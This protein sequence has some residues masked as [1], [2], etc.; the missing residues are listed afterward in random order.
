MSWRPRLNGRS[1]PLYRQIVDALREDVKT[2][3]VAQ[4]TRLPPQRD[5]AKSLG[6]T[7]GTVARAYKQAQAEGLI[8]SGVGSG[9][10]VQAAARNIDD[11]G[12]GKSGLAR[13]SVV[14]LAQNSI[15]RLQHRADISALLTTLTAD[16]DFIAKI[17]YAPHAGHAEHRAAA[18][19]WLADDAEFAP[20]PDSIVICNGG[21]HALDIA[22]RTL[23]RPDDIILVEDLTYPGLRAA[24]A[25]FGLKLHPVGMDNEGL[26]P[27]HL[28][29]AAKK[30]GA[31]VLF[32]V[33]TM[34]TATAA[35]Q[36]DSRRRELAQIIEKHD[37]HVIE[38]G[39]FD[40]LLPQRQAPIASLIPQRCL[41][42]SSIGKV[43]SSALHCGTLV[44]PPRLEPRA[45]DAMRASCWSASPLAVAMAIEALLDG[46]A[47][48]L[49]ARN[50]AEAAH[51]QAI[52]RSIL[53]GLC[54]I[55]GSPHAYHIWITLETARAAAE[56]RN[57]LRAAN[58]AVAPADAFW[59]ARDQEAPPAF[60]LSLMSPE[61]SDMMQAAVE[62][63][64]LV[65]QGSYG[66]I[67]SLV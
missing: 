57:G 3:R 18:A 61:T 62:R 44:L 41:Y 20:A 19:K 38:D 6:V 43:A 47:H 39:V 24:A 59:A 51:R 2:A 17:S 50:K 54:E 27:K 45:A 36:S 28:D 16:D 10:Y 1:G 58:V 22:L 66:S 5:L 13:Q 9:T 35:T 15:V 26:A 8:L 32:T 65:L 11:A 64:A 29:Q 37:L 49:L 7:V 53:A 30:T 55:S 33:P 21:Q 63:I 34:H 23:A 42:I 48:K 12:D 67:P 31:R 40:P 25:I 60:R 46:S 56:F 14:D 52:A 4:G